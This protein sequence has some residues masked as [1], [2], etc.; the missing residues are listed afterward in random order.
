[1]A[2]VGMDHGTTG[3][4]F[5]ILSK[6]IEHF[7]LGREELSKGKVSAIEELSKRID[8]AEIKLMAITYA[9]G[10]A[11]TTIKPLEKVENRGIISIGGAG[12]VT[13]GGTAVY[14][15]IEKSG[16]PTVL[17]PGLHRN[18]PCLDER[19]KAAYSH[20]GSAE[21]VSISYNAHLETGWE[22]LIVSDI[23]S[24]TVTI[25][26]QDGII[27]GAMDACIGAMGIIHGP[28]DLEMIRAIDDG[29]K[30]ANEC[31][32]HAGAVKIAGIDTKV[33]RAKDELIKRYL[34]GD[35]KARLAI[36]TMA[37]TIT[38]EIWGLISI[39]DK[40]DGIILT[41]SVGAM[42][43]PINFYSILK[44][45]LDCPMEVRRLPPTSGSLGS[46]Q[47]ARD[48]YQ[49]KKEILGIEVESLP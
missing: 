17:I 13:G 1:M 47:I 48:I 24:N 3:I 45:Q 7:K 37:M 30:T 19:F 23:S 46:A 5:T 6:E 44:K 9:M 2:F 27:K 49:G 38:M 20:H 32:S 31:F 36:D 42:K 15:E 34:E 21:K 26:I 33:A 22:N 18:L 16:I 12:K 35:Y 29:Y 28:L 39:A 4:S 11:I 8:P 41:G 40:I 14:S 43:E 10:D 25:L